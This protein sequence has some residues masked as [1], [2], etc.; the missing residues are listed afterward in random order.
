M[1]RRQKHRRDRLKLR[2][3]EGRF[4]SRYA[5][6]E[7]GHDQGRCKLGSGHRRSRCRATQKRCRPTTGA[8]AKQVQVQDM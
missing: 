1:I 7:T 6:A 2:H 5:G 4:R 8:V 3:I